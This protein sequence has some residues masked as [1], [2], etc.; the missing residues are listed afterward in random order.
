MTFIGIAEYMLSPT[1]DRKSH[2]N[3]S[4]GCIE[5]GGGSQQFRGLLAHFLK[6]TISTER[7]AIL[8]HACNNP[9]CS[10]VYHLYWGTYSENLQDSYTAGRKSI[11]QHLEE[12][13]SKE[14]VRKIKSDAAKAPRKRYGNRFSKFE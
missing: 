10:N 6:T 8:C 1:A 7:I 11:Q 12:R 2:L 14:D 4:S 3:L 13:Y 9:K 5:I